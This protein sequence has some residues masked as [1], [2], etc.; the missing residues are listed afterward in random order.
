MVVLDLGTLVA[1]GW[2]PLVLVAILGLV[3]VGLY[4]N[5]RKHM[6]N[7]DVPVDSERPA[8]APFPEPKE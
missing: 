7:I 2:L 6:R 1:P 5:M 8:S 3:I 4:F